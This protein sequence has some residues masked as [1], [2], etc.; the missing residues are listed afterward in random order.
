MT[1]SSARAR[2]VVRRAIRTAA[3]RLPE[4]F[5]PQTRLAVAYSGG[6]DSTCLLHA[7]RNAHR[8]LELTAVHVDHALRKD[9]AEDAQRIQ[10]LA[11]A[12]GVECVVRRVD[13]A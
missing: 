5:A 8:G 9:S 6:Q 12:I 13:V 4:L 2:E 1:T 11:A 7:L 3:V 10:R